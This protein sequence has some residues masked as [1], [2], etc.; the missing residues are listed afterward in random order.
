[1]YGRDLE[2]AQLTD[3]LIAKRIV[4][5]YSPSGAGKTSLIQAGVMPRM[6]A[7]GFTVM[8]PIRVARGTIVDAQ[9]DT[10]P[11]EEHA[12]DARHNNPYLLAAVSSL[13]GAR[14]VDQRLDPAKV[15][16]LTLDDY[17]GRTA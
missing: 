12:S 14:P 3:L 16:S 4:L 10:I 8:P 11:T 2:I 7:D 1:M 6:S 13:E 17:L 5:L 9:A 15:G